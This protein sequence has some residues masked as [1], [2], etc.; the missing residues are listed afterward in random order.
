MRSSYATAR[1]ATLLKTPNARQQ[2]GRRR[3]AVVCVILALALGSGLLG[4]T[5]R[6]T[7][8]LSSRPVTGPFNY[9]PS[10]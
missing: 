10:E 9:F 8:D 1:G 7:D 4:S 6:P 5:I 3:L 2:A